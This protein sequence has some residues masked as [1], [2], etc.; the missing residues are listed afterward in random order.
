MMNFD[1]DSLNAVKL[2]LGELFTMFKYGERILP[3]LED[4]LTFV[5]EIIPLLNEMQDSL[6]ESTR[7]MPKVSGHISNI[8][9]ATEMATHEILDTV[10][11]IVNKGAEISA[12]FDKVNQNNMSKINLIGRAKTEF[13]AIL[14]GNI[15]EKKIKKL[16]KSIE[17]HQLNRAN[18]LANHVNVL[19]DDIQSRSME[20]TMALQ[21]QDITS[22][23]LSSVNN[24]IASIQDKIIGL[25]ANFTDSNLENLKIDT[26]NK[27]FDA[28][29][30]Y[31]DKTKS[32]MIADEIVKAK[33]MM[34]NQDD[35]DNLLNS[36]TKN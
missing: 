22:Q 35:I 29:A 17:R 8:N 9:H 24:L 4:L 14:D 31:E 21:V 32:Q 10:D 19:I 28:D 13:E 12:Y 16:I 27:S 20:I 5:T 26:S 33:N 23:Q 3:F 25:L 15:N 34:S 7:K 1:A 2:K 36:T 11:V 30:K 6:S 18:R